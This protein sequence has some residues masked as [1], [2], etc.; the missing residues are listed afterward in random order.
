MRTG[1]AWGTD[2]LGRHNHTANESDSH[3]NFLDRNPARVGLG[4]LILST[5]IDALS[6]SL[7]RTSVIEQ[8]RFYGPGRR[9]LSHLACAGCLLSEV[10]R[11]FRHGFGT[12]ASQKCFLPIHVRPP[13]VVC[14]CCGLLERLA[15]G[16]AAVHNS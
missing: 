7:K 4:R 11:S 16:V 13:W 15:S 2:K 3:I 14:R 5:L 1:R 9:L 10:R 8:P 12:P 6:K